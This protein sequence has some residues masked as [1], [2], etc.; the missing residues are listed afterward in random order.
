MPQSERKKKLEGHFLPHTLTNTLTHT[1]Q[2]RKEMKEPNLH[3]FQSECCGGMLVWACLS[4]VSAFEHRWVFAMPF[5][6][7]KPLD[8]PP[9]FSPIANVFLVACRALFPE[10]FQLHGRRGSQVRRGG[11]DD[12]PGAPH[13]QPQL[14]HGACVGRRPE[15]AAHPPPAEDPRQGGVLR[16]R[17]RHGKEGVR[18]LRRA[19]NTERPGE[20]AGR[21]AICILRA[22]NSP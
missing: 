2:K 16:R 9:V 11:D 19:R 3:L 4:L 12:R 14:Q 7:N 18:W 8:G 20:R 6:L 5:S 15:G 13:V 17:A 10:P 21:S 1:Q 22:V